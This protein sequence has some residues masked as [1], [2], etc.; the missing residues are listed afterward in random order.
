MSEAVSQDFRSLLEDI[1]RQLA[2]LTERVKRIE[3]GATPAPHPAVSAA[4]SIPQPAQ[5]ESISEE[6]LLAIS[7]ALGAYLGVGVHIRQIRLIG[8]HAWAAEGRVSIQA[9]HRLHG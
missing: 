2:V 9:S 1:R 3:N 8:S 6:E 7:A 5:P 4:S